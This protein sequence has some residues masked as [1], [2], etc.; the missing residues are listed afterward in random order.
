MGPVALSDAP[1]DITGRSRCSGL[2]ATLVGFF[3]AATEQDDEPEGERVL[4]GYRKYEGEYVVLHR[5]AS[6]E[7]ATNPRSRGA[8][9]CPNTDGTCPEGP[10]TVEYERNCSSKR[11][12]GPADRSPAL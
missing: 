4:D 2:S 6:L 3:E 9:R 1:C 7:D 10:E 8:T 5:E 11:R 12:L